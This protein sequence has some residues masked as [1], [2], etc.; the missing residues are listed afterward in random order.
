MKTKDHDSTPIEMRNLIDK[1]VQPKKDI[2]E[3]K[4]ESTT[5]T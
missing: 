1:L 5:T 2:I 4:Y 3:E